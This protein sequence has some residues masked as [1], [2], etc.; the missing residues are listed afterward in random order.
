MICSSM[1]LVESILK[2]TIDSFWKWSYKQREMKKHLSK[3][4]KKLVREESLAFELT[5]PHF[6]PHSSVAETAAA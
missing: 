3:T 6:Q 2:T 5:T 4:Y 1:K